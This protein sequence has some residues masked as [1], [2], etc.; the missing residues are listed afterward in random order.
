M[1]R[2][3]VRAGAACREGAHRGRRRR[4]PPAGAAAAP[5]RSAS[6]PN[7]Y[8]VRLVGVVLR[9]IDGEWAVAGLD[10]TVD[11]ALW[12][13]STGSPGQCEEPEKELRRSSECAREAR[14]VD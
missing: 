7:R 12:R 4:V 11:R 10:M 5:M 13:N 3:A 14:D 2:L 6:S 8:A 1:P 9:E